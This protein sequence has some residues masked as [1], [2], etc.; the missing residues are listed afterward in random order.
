LDFDI[1][2]SLV[3]HSSLRS[4][5][6]GPDLNTDPSPDILDLA[7][8]RRNFSDDLPFIARLLGKFESRYPSQ[9]LEIRDALSRRDGPAAANAAHRVAGE[10][11]VFYAQVARQEALR[12]EDLARA[13]DLAAAA[14]ACERLSQEL[15]RLT[16]ALRALAESLP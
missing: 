5:H 7:A 8:L 2:W 1:L 9:L 10:A 4:R 13:G 3:V 14:E 6:S 16:Q 15:N 12:L 11:S